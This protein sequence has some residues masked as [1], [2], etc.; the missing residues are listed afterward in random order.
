MK[1]EE[2]ERGEDRERQEFARIG[3]QELPTF[4]LTGRGH[5]E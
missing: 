1:V 4:I 2:E 3:I 5:Y